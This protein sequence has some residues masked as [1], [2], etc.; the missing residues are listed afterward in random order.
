M[1]KNHVLNLHLK[2]LDKWGGDEGTT[3]MPHK[4]VFGAWDAIS[5]GDITCE[6][7]KRHLSTATIS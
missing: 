7:K 2:K 4:W 5:S 3:I 6:F 1:F